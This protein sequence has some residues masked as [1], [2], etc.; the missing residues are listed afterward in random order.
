MIGSRSSESSRPLPLLL[1]KFVKQN[2]GMF[3]EL[4]KRGTSRMSALLEV[5]DLVRYFVVRRSLVGRAL[6]T[7]RAVVHERPCARSATTL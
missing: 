7:V 3:D 4:R 1:T 6:A 5:E 2:A